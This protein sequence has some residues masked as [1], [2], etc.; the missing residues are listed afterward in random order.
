MTAQHDPHS[1]GTRAPAGTIAPH[2]TATQNDNANPK[3]FIGIF[4]KHRQPHIYCKVFR[5]SSPI[6]SKLGL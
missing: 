3:K 4:S 5:F 1:Y 2:Y 6:S